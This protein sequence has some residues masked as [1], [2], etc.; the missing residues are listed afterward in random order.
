MGGSCVRVPWAAMAVSRSSWALGVRGAIGASRSPASPNAPPRPWSLR[1]TPTWPA[2]PPPVTWPRGPVAARA[3]RSRRQ[4]V[5]KGG[6]ARV[7]VTG[8]RI[9]EAALAA[10]RTRSPTCRPATNAC[11]PGSATAARWRRRASVLVAYWHI[12]HHRRDLPRPGRRLVRAPRPLAA[13]RRLVH[14]R[15]RLEQPSHCKR[16]APHRARRYFPQHRRMWIHSRGPRP[17][18]AR[19]SFT[20][21]R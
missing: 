4:A 18:C 9:K 19:H 10:T 6:G 7:P 2:F 21:P 20:H 17:R 14:Q 13:T 8:R 5:L 1:S 3:M 11:L 12:F 15:E 16:P